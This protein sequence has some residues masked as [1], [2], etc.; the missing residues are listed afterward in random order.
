MYCTKLKKEFCT[1]YQV[2]FLFNVIFG[3]NYY[4]LRRNNCSLFFQN[5]CLY[6]FYVISMVF[7]YAL[8][9]IV[10]SKNFTFKASTRFN[11]QP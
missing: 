2:N 3:G 7:P 6:R 1:I 11:F 10:K 9:T 8:K 5:P 4:Y